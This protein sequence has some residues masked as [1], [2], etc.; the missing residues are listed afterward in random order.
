[1]WKMYE[2]TPMAKTGLLLR[3]TDCATIEQI[4]RRQPDWLLISE[5]CMFPLA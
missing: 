3:P 1:M 5:E 4:G 2:E